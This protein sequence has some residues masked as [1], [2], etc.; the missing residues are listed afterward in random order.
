MVRVSVVSTWLYAVMLAL[1][2][3]NAMSDTPMAGLDD[4]HALLLVMCIP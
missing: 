3:I 2:L 1:C 4:F